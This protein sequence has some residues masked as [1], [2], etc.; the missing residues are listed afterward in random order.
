MFKKVLLSSAI[1]AGV[2]VSGTSQ[3]GLFSIAV[4]APAVGLLYTQ[5]FNDAED[6]LN[7]FDVANL[8]AN[9]PGFNAA[10][11]SA[12]AVLDY[13][14]LDMAFEYPVNSAAL[15]FSV[16]S[17]GIT[18]T[19]SGA[20]RAESNDLLIDFLQSEGGDLLNRIN[21]T[22]AEVSA[23]DPIAGNPNSL[24]STQLDTIHNI[25]ISDNNTSTRADTFDTDNKFDIGIR[26]AS[27][28]AE[29]NDIESVQLPLS[30]TFNFDNR[31]GHKLQ[32]RLPVSYTLINN[33]AESYTLGSSLAYSFPVN[34]QLSFTPAIT[35]GAAGSVNLGT[36]AALQ[37]LSLTTRYDFEMLNH[38][39][40][41]GNTLAR[42]RTLELDFGDYVINPDLSNNAIVNSL[43]W[44][45][46]P[47][48]W[49]DLDVF[50]SD[51]RFYGDKLYSERSNEIGFSM[52]PTH[53]R[54]GFSDFAF[55][56]GASYVFTDRDELNGF[57]F[58][59]NSSF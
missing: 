21:K 56:G 58:N 34:D 39:W 28:R 11:D 26:F 49:A 46:V 19:F 51:T 53:N 32:I 16:P 45:S 22:L 36:V 55:R 10:T 27:H 42:L 57:K 31:P 52:T 54:F 20:T 15:I 59:M 38:Q 2:L 13:R 3:A 8:T 35:Y 5:S 40:R 37:T 17:L 6:S 48:D 12:T 24:M 50:F 44:R 30:Y 9:L 4:T 43:T 33:Q 23:T 14:G 18:Q 47:V 1:T 25:A 7:A 29:G 41:F